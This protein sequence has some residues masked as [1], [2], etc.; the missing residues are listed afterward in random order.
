MTSLSADDRLQVIREATAEYWKHIIP[1]VQIAFAIHILLFGLFLVMDIP[2][3]LITNA[4]SIVGYVACLVAIRR[5]WYRGAGLFISVEIVVHA[6]IATWILG[7]DSNFHLYVFC[8]V[9]II[10][11][12][13]QTA[14]LRRVSLS[15]AV[16]AVIV[17]GFAYRQHLPVTANFGAR[18]QEM[19][20]IVNAFAATALLLHATALTVRFNLAMQMSLFHSASRDSLTNLYTRRRVLQR[21][22][23]LGVSR[24][25]VSTALI[26]IDIDHFKRIN[27]RHGHD[28]GDVV[29]QQVAAIISGSVRG[30]DIAARWGGEEFLVLMPDSTL[31]LAQRVAERIMVQIRWQTGLIEKYGITLSATLAVAVMQADES[32]RDTLNRA[33]QMLYEGKQQG[34]DR[35]MLAS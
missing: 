20:G 8:I 3:M 34:R 23:Q 1:I 2:V 9:P 22:R 32:F 35:L 14:P 30:T 10:A 26:L 25:K 21:I 16:L 15:L 24:K 28:V 11:F 7:W 19:F 17:V 13:F 12:N 33:D 4:A 5:R 31:E 6:A 29:L 18:A 27:D